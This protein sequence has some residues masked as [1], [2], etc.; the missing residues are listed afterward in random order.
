[1]EDHHRQSLI[2]QNELSSSSS[3][4]RSSSPSGVQRSNTS[5]V[6]YKERPQEEEEDYSIY[7]LNDS[8]S[9]AKLLNPYYKNYYHSVN[10]PH[11]LSHND[12]F[13]ERSNSNVGIY[14][15]SSSSAGY[16]RS[17]SPPIPTHAKKLPSRSYKPSTGRERIS[18][19]H[20]AF[21]PE[22]RKKKNGYD[23]PSFEEFYRE[24]RNNYDFNDSHASF[25]GMRLLTAF[26]QNGK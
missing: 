21:S 26:S 1:M 18:P 12:G 24:K 20:S 3:R 16:P 15:P 23:D 19:S 22:G 14:R 8:N 6:F 5:S 2:L 7:F 4:P 11:S 13:F 9:V 25:E 17:S 10:K